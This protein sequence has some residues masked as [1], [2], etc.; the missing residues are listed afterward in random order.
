MIDDYKTFA[1]WSLAIFWLLSGYGALEAPNW[2][3]AVGMT[4]AF[5][6]ATVVSFY[7]FGAR[8]AVEAAEMYRVRLDALRKPGEQKASL[9]DHRGEVLVLSE[10]WNEADQ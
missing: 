5:I 2:R 4:F 1:A 8:V 3:W 7:R 10:R 6:L 9:F